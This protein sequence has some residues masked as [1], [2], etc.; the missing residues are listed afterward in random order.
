MAVLRITAWHPDKAWA[1]ASIP[2]RNLFKR[3]ERVSTLRTTELKR[4]AERICH[5][6]LLDVPVRDGAMAHT[7]TSFLQGYGADVELLSAEGSKMNP[8]T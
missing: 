5:R 2:R 1:S 6:Q 7:L 3:M 8:L 4:T